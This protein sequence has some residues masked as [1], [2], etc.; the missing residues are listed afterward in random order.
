MKHVRYAVQDHPAGWSTWEL[1]SDWYAFGECRFAL[2]CQCNHSS[3]GPLRSVVKVLGTVADALAVCETLEAA[4]GGVKELPSGCLV[5]GSSAV[6][7]GDV[8]Y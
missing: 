1:C 3:G 8:P 7:A 5:V 6:A 2:W 4:Q